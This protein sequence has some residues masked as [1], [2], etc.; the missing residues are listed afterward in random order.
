MDTKQTRDIHD[1]CKYLGTFAPR[2]EIEW[3]PIVP[4]TTVLQQTQDNE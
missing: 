4:P 3:P 2:D 1:G